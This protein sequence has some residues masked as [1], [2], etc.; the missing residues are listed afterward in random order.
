MTTTAATTG[1]LEKN[2]KKI[3]PYLIRVIRGGSLSHA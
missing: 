1:S 2:F 3:E